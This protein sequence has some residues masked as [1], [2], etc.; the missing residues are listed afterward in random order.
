MVQ[1]KDGSVKEQFN[2]LKAK[3]HFEQVPLAEVKKIVES[4]GQRIALVSEKKKIFAR[5]PK[6]QGNGGR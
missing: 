2:M 1:Y 5:H 6:V 3:T 4:T